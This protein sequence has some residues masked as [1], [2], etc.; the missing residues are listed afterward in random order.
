MGYYM[1]VFSKGTEPARLSSI[2]ERLAGNGSAAK[3]LTDDPEDQWEAAVL[4]HSD[5]REFAA[6]E[7][8]LV[9]PGALGANELAEMIEQVSRCEPACA[10]AWINAYLSSVKTIYAFQV[11]SAADH[12]DGWAAIHAAMV[13][14]RAVAGGIQQAD[15]EG[16]SNEEG[17]H[18]LWQFSDK[19]SGSWWMAVL[20][21]KGAWV[22][23]QI[24]LGN[25]LHRKAFKEGRVPD[26]VSPSTPGERG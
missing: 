18:I 9:T 24:D 7:R 16:F 22:T 1:R 8:N 23:Y 26:G 2:R 25:K 3:V 13:A 5:G 20:D 21:E 17:F 4:A 19:V 12:G 6:V 11:L 14:C 15:G 10:A